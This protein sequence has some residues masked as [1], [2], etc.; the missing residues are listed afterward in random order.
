VREIIHAFDIGA[1]PGDVFRAITSEQGLSGWWTTKVRLDDDLIHFTFED[2]F[3]PVMR[4]TRRDEAKAVEWAL[5]RGHD[6]WS[7]S[8]FSFDLDDRD[9]KTGVLFRMSYGQ[10]LPD[11][12]YGIYNFNWGYYLD[13]L[14]L[15]CEEGKGKPFQPKR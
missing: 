3:H 2:P 14:R 7:G 8:T 10:E 13:S 6:P 11:E 12:V 9:G 4:V 1:S 15:L 5:E